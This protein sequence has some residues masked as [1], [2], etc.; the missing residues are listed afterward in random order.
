MRFHKFLHTLNVLTILSIIFILVSAWVRG[1]D[2]EI[3]AAIFNVIMIGALLYYGV[4]ELFMYTTFRTGKIA[5]WGIVLQTILCFG[6]YAFIIW[7]S[8][9]G[10]I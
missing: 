3:G 1:Q 8:V 7:F 6:P 5:V 9:L 4:L 2:G 10:Y